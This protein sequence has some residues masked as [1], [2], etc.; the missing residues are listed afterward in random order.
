MKNGVKFVFFGTGDFAAKVLE[1]LC[2]N[3]FVPELVVTTPDKP[4]GRK[5]ELQPS[6][7]KLWNMEH[8]TW[9]IKLDQPDKLDSS[10]M[11][12]VSRF[13]PDLFIVADYGK[14]IPLE[15][16]NIPKYGA[17]NVHPSLLPKF[18][19]P[20]PI[21]SFIL[22]D[23]EETG[24]TII[25]IDEEV[26]H[27]DIVASSKLQALSSKLYHKELEEKLA[28]LGGELLVKV[29]PDWIEGKIK[30]QEQDHSQAT[31]TKKIT[32]EDS[33]INL[34]EPAENIAR[35]V[36]ALTPWPGTYFFLNNPPATPERSDG[37][38]GKRIIITEVEIEDGKLAIKRVKPE[39]KNE[40]LYED[41]LRGNRSTKP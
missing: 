15:I 31:F 18:R 36:R 12:Q 14:I 32:K 30:T 19:G 38:H 35:K 16:L 2:Q 34:N 11:I 41:F 27:G 28:E 22:S 40:M 7:V 23:E 17:L 8:K 20:S 21:Q 33:L 5:M 10:F 4:K 24:V 13:K 37:G 1:V 6:P 9:N 3:G 39:G 25:K 29:I 26:D